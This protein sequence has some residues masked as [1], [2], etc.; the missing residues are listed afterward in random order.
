MRHDDN[1]SKH[2]DNAAT[3]D[4][5][6]AATNDNDDAATNDNIVVSVVV[7]S[8]GNFHTAVYA[9]VSRLSLL[10]TRRKVLAS[11]HSGRLVVV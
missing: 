8:Q 6:N 7:C 2:N 5:D 1:Y 3:N 11:R 4:N 9:A 10:L